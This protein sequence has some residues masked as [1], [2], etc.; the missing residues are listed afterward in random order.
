MFLTSLKLT[1]SYQVFL[2]SLSLVD[3]LIPPAKDDRTGV[4][5]GGLDPP[6][7]SPSPPSGRPRDCME[8]MS[9]QDELDLESA[10]SSRTETVRCG[11]SGLNLVFVGEGSVDESPP[12]CPLY[13]PLLPP[14]IPPSWGEAGASRGDNK[15]SKEVIKNKHSN[16][17]RTERLGM[18]VF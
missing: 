6:T 17:G 5:A 13:I 15:L 18:G 8:W 4:E 3:F 10:V 16:K 1:K 7:S 12:P 11:G 9:S 14:K 2:S